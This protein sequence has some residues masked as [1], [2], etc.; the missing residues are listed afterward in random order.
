MLKFSETILMKLKVPV[1]QERRI[2]ETIKYSKMARDVVRIQDPGTPM[3]A[4]FSSSRVV[5]GSWSRERCRKHCSVPVKEAYY[6]LSWI[7]TNVPT[8][9]ARLQRH[10]I[11][12]PRLMGRIKIGIGLTIIL[13]SVST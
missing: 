7:C 8:I 2:C 1:L 3:N 6:R 4:N 11:P 13:T 12:G 10:R 9:M 5:N